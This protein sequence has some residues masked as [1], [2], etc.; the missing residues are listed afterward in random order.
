MITKFL[1][2]VEN[3]S[4]VQ[5]VLA[6]FK[7]NLVDGLRLSN[8]AL[9]GWEKVQLQAMRHDVAVLVYRSLA[10]QTEFVVPSAIMRELENHCHK[11]LDINRESM[12][13]LRCLLDLIQDTEII[14]LKGPAV[15]MLA[16]PNSGLREYFDFDIFI[17]LGDWSRVREALRQLNYRETESLYEVETNFFAVEGQEL[18]KYKHSFRHISVVGRGPTPLYL[19]IHCNSFDLGFSRDAEI[20]ERRVALPEIACNVSS[21]GVADLII[22]SCIHLAH[23]NYRKLKWFVDIFALVE[24]TGGGVNWQL[25]MRRCQNPGIRA[26]VYYGLL[27]TRCLFNCQIPGWVLSE[28]RPGLM[29]RAVFKLFWRERNILQPGN[30]GLISQDLKVQML[31]LGNLCNK[32][33]YLKARIWPPDELIAMRFPSTRSVSKTRRRLAHLYILFRQRLKASRISSRRDSQSKS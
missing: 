17:H 23:H 3:Q 12:E 10:G 22:H 18:V 20:W 4:I 2:S 29:R 16:Y 26:S 19:D 14:L 13:K 9:V 24:H 31:I 6:N 5:C 30:F 11:T 15:E 8:P 7:E 1:C 27:Y 33:A 28:L 25:I 21:L 32:L